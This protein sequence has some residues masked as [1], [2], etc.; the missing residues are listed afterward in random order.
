[1]KDIAVADRCWHWRRPRARKSSAHR[2]TASKFARRVNVVSSA[3]GVAFD[4]FG[5]VGSWWDPEHTYSGNAANL[6]PRCSSPADAFAS[7]FPRRRRGRAYAR[8]LCRAGQADRVLTGSL[9]PLLYEAT[10]G[11]MDVQV[12]DRRRRIADDA[13]LS[14]SAGF[15]NGGADKLAAGGRSGARGQM[16]RFRTYATSRPTN[17]RRAPASRSGTA[18]DRPPLDAPRSTTSRHCADCARDRRCTV[19]P[20]MSS[21]T[22]VSSIRSASGRNSA[23]ISA[24]P[25]TETGSSPASRSA[26]STSVRDLGALGAPVADRASARCAGA[27]EAAR[28]GSRRSCGP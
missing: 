21:S 28:A 16:K 1:M 12:E 22:S 19:S 13:R 14:R 8:H 2:Q 10:T 17:A 18:G 9:G 20:A 7:A 6:Q 26:S 15:C 23:K 27:R 24:P 25:M 4:A 11:V 3:G 5:D